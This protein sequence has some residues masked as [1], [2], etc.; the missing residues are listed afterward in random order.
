M[1]SIPLEIT[2][3]TLEHYQESSD[4]KSP[5]MVHPFETASA[6]FDLPISKTKGK[7]FP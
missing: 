7:K 1:M 6:I 4:L 3:Y 5:I 2:R